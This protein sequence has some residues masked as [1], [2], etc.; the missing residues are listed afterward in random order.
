MTLADKGRTEPADPNSSSDRVPH[1]F[2]LLEEQAAE[3]P[4]AVAI[5]TPDG[6][7]TYTQWLRESRQVAAALAADGVGPGDT[8]ALI[9][10][11]RLEWLAVAFGAAAVG[12]R[13]APFNTWLKRRELAYLLELAKP[14]VLVTVDRWARQDFLGDLGQILP[15]LATAP[16]RVIAMSAESVATRGLTQYESWRSVDPT[17]GGPV[18][19]PDDIAFVLFTSGSTAQPKGVTLTHRDL[20]ANG[21][22]IGERQGLGA[23]DRL[24]LVSPLFWSLGSANALFATLTHGT[25]L[26]LM[27]S[28]EAGQALQI[29]EAE[30]CT[31]IY[32]L[33]VITHALLTHRGFSPE[34]VATLQRGLTFGSPSEMR[35]VVEDL[36]VTAICNIYGSTELYGNCVVSPSDAP[37]EDRLTACGPPLDGVQI[38]I[39]DPESGRVQPPGATGEIHVRGR[40]T[41][42]YLGI[43][44]TIT[45]VTGEDGWFA[46]GDLGELDDRGWLTF[47]GRR[48][49]MIKTAGIN[50]SPAEVE[51]VI[52]EHGDVVAVAVTG[53]SHPIRG[54]QVVA[55]V[56]LRPHSDLQPEDLRAWALERTASYKVP[57]RI[58]LVNEFPTTSTGKLARRELRTI[59]EAKS[60][61]DRG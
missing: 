12:A 26:V 59:A 53:V 14:T 43:D 18:H 45:P 49:E 23:D 9:A 31:A 27:S 17:L 10:P 36:G 47:A 61:V 6:R 58:F 56:Q 20:I 48:S 57:A 15:S 8:V 32:T 4:D 24:L 44:G 52:V 19:P 22:E 25:C 11:N 2:A 21:F 42:G 3:T 41:P 16:P 60:E 55:F 34:R 30:R 40:V 13:L 5:V 39:V 7:W 28:F 37:I 51:S 33:T 29:I 35:R 54:E 1:I 46:T 50:V 38:R